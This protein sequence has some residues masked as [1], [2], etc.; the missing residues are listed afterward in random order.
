MK[1]F[2]K[3]AAAMML[4]AAVAA[5]SFAA[6]SPSKQQQQ[7]TFPSYNGYNQD[8]PGSGSGSGSGGGSS[9]GGGSGSGGTI[10]AGG[11]GMITPVTSISP[12]NPGEAGMGNGWIGG[13][14]DWSYLVE[15]QELRSQWANLLNPYANNAVQMFCFE[16]NGN[17]VSGWRWIMHQDGHYHCY[18]FIQD[19]NGSYGALL[20]NATTPDGYQVNENGEWVVNGIVQIR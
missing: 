9:S 12:S 18:Y 14:N 2:L 1:Q 13:G 17:V 7:P 19:H 5:T 8:T 20:R 15:G 6:T 10:Y 3:I 16:S 11:P 4:V